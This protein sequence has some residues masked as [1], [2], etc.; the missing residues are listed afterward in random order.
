MPSQKD[1]RRKIKAVKNI[2]KVTN[3]MET[4]ANIKLQQAMRVMNA[5]RTFTKELYSFAK[6]LSDSMG[7]DSL[8]TIETAKVREVKKQLFIVIASDKG[9]CGV[10]NSR[11]LN[12]A[13]DHILCEMS[14][15]GDVSIMTIGKKASEYFARR[16]MPVAASFE[17]PQS[18]EVKEFSRKMV[19]SS[20]SD[21]AGGKYDAV[22]IVYNSFVSISRQEA[23]IFRLLP[24]FRSVDGSPRLPLKEM[25]SSGTHEMSSEYIFEPSQAEILDSIIKKCLESV[26]LQVLK[27]SGA[28]ENA[29]RMVAMQQATLNAD[30]MIG[31]LVLVYNKIRQASITKEI[32]EVVSS[33]EALKS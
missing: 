1:I 25:F 32:I 27:E 16:K 30:E 15:G 2:K 3:A 6:S 19:S 18:S 7:P 21:F 5:S 14:E 8:D 4:I 26:F 29:A 28:G 24:A 12:F 11:L 17:F 23:V 20:V 33:V 22:Y 9:L 13:A 10:F 31:R